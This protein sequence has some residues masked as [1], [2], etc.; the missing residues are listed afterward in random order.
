MDPHLCYEHQKTRW[1]REDS[2]STNL[3]LK[4]EATGARPLQARRPKWIKIDIFLSWQ[5]PYMVRL[6]RPLPRAQKPESHQNYFFCNGYGPRSKH[7]RQQAHPT[8]RS[9]IKCVNRRLPRSTH[10]NNSKH[11]SR[12]GGLEGKKYSLYETYRMLD[13]KKEVCP[14][15]MGFDPRNPTTMGLLPAPYDF[16]R[17][18]VMKYHAEFSSHQEIRKRIWKNIEKTTLQLKDRCPQNEIQESK[19]RAKCITFSTCNIKSQQAQVKW[20]KH[21]EW[22]RRRR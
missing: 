15:Q 10:G 22:S 19:A 13:H 9:K 16:S 11:P 21:E 14:M 8:K 1:K 12:G 18:Y 5:S 4:L 20:I 17:I 7:N 2:L 3:V 6:W